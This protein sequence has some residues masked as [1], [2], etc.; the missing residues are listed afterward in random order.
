MASGVTAFTYSRRVNVAAAKSW[1]S[2]CCTL[3]PI[4]VPS[5]VWLAE[6]SCFQTA[7]PAVLELRLK[8]N[9][10]AWMN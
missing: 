5:R 6:H 4:V 1:A 10:D 2:C 8:R 3:R 7:G 9:D